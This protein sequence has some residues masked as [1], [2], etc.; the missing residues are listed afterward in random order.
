MLFLNNYSRD[1]QV[2]R[3]TVE[4]VGENPLGSVLIKLKPEPH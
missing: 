3:F 2:L 1:L 4:R